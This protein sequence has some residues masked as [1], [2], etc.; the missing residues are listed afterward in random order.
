MHPVVGREGRGK[1]QYSVVPVAKTDRLCS[2]RVLARGV[3][4]AFA[5]RHILRGYSP[6][7]RTPIWASHDNDLCSILLLAPLVQP[8]E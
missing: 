2:N 3:Y 6:Q 4:R 5:G 7:G 1:H 8:A